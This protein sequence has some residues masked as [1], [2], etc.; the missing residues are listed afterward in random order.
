MDINFHYHTVK[1]IARMAG[2]NEDDAQLIAAYSQ[3]VDDYTVWANYFIYNVPEYARSL[4]TNL[5]VTYRFYTVTTGFD[6]YLDMA[7]LAIPKYQTEV[8]VPFHFIPW[9]SLKTLPSSDQTQYRTQAADITGSSLIAT[10]LR[11]AKNI[12]MGET[13]PVEK[14]FDLIRVG[15]TLHIFADTY[16]HQGFSGYHGWENYSY[17]TELK[18]AA[19]LEPVSDSDSPDYF[20]GVYS[21]GHANVG[22]APD[23]TYAYFGMSYAENENQKNKNS[24]TGRYSRSNTQV[25]SDA[26]KQI[27]TVL[28][29]MNHENND[30]SEDEWQTVLSLLKQGFALRDTTEAELSAK[31]HRICP[32]INYHYNKKELWE[33]Q[34]VPL[35]GTEKDAL[36]LSLIAAENE[37]NSALGEQAINGFVYKTASDDFFHFNLFA[38]EIRDAV[39]N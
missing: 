13:N 7:R 33:D 32:N 39:I 38:K 35:L 36:D 6:G 15:I 14:R 25:F 18:D 5:G 9:S 1:T 22:H 31:W 11:N 24:Y 17:I 4:A 12:Y 20:A 26:A 37:A 10:L 21:I 29:Q 3:F 27:F 28:Y 34:L 8:V 2:F 23:M 30:P 16:A 19:T